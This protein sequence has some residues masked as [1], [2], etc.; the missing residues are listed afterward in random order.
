MRVLVRRHLALEHVKKV[1]GNVLFR[2][3]RNRLK[4]FSKT[5]KRGDDCRELSDETRCGLDGILARDVSGVLVIEG[6]RGDGC[7][8]RVH[9]LSVVWKLTHQRQNLRRELIVRRD[10]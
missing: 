5:L 1:G 10:V 2:F 7:A 9:W 3:R 8:Q 4:P 6:E